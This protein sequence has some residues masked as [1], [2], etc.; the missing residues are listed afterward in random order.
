MPLLGVQ[1]LKQQSTPISILSADV[2]FQRLFSTELIQLYSAFQLRYHIVM[3][4]SLHCLFTIYIIHVFL[5]STDYLLGP[6]NHNS[7]H[8]QPRIVLN[9]PLV[10][11]YIQSISLVTVEQ[12]ERL[13]NS[14]VMRCVREQVHPR[15]CIV[16]DINLHMKCIL[17]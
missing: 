10:S 14:E 7:P 15:V 17:V 3:Q 8:F 13:K 6:I 4:C 11:I 9:A 5:D 16:M 12:E 1:Q 2:H